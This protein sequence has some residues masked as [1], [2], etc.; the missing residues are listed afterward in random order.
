MA[1]VV[2]I[3]GLW[4][5]P[6]SWEHWKK[7]YEDAGHTVL[8]PA[9][10]GLE[11]RDVK[12]IR[13]DP[14]ALEGLGV[15]EVADHYEGI[16]SDLPT[17]PIIM[18]HSFGGLIVQ[19]LLSRGLGAAGVSID[20]AQPAGLYALPWSTI[21]A[22]SPILGH[23]TTRHKAVP[24]TPKQFNYAFTNELTLAE[25]QAIY[26]RYHI[27]A[28]GRALWEGAAGGFH[29]GVTAVDYKAERAP[30]MIVA[31]GDDH[32]VPPSINRANLRKYRHSPSVTEYREYP[33]RTHFTVGQT[34]WEEVSDDAIEW[35]M[36]V[37]A[38]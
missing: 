34:G 24:L 2:L 7:R 10:P 18:G 26:D 6:L 17:A 8:A 13:D 9:W 29:K 38:A 4:M 20:P 12:D 32:I 3:H 33:G 25:S 1:T 21:R 28:T 16:V 14:S 19:I 5:T 11:G 37:A 15:G 35:S 22:A 30:L 36:D 23:P 27:P 31:G